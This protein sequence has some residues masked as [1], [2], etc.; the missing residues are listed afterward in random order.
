MCVCAHSCVREAEGVLIHAARACACIC[1]SMSAPLCMSLSLPSSHPP[2]SLPL[3]PSS[4]LTGPCLC[5][6]LCLCLCLCLASIPSAHAVFCCYL[7]KHFGCVATALRSRV[8]GQD[9]TS[10]TSKR[11]CS[12]CLRDLKD[13]Q[14]APHGARAF[15][16]SWRAGAMGLAEVEALASCG[17]EALVS[18]RRLRRP[19]GSAY[20]INVEYNQLDP[21]LRSTSQFA[22]GDAADPGEGSPFRDFSPHQYDFPSSWQSK[23]ERRSIGSAFVSVS[24]LCRLCFVSALS[25]R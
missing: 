9:H 21:L 14:A 18:C 11:T 2:P 7:S 24:S 1:A 17:V 23:E 12:L 16:S 20:T 6:R 13:L 25:L 10:A 8:T 3:P 19:D 22:Q 15:A 5:F 4:S